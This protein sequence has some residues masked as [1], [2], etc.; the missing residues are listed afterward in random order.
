MIVNDPQWLMSAE[1]HSAMKW[2]LLINSWRIHERRL[3]IRLEVWR[4]RLFCHKQ[5]LYARQ[6]FDL[7]WSNIVNT[8][9]LD[10]KRTCKWGYQK[11]P[12]NTIGFLLKNQLA[13]TRSCLN[14][15]VSSSSPFLKLKTVKINYTSAWHSCLLCA[16]VSSINIMVRVKATSMK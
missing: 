16:K 7:T 14:A 1:I 11:T 9:R 3:T 15:I 5:T 8:T 10:S 4:I 13:C 2:G 12:L 6:T